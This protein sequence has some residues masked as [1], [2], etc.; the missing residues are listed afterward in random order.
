MTVLSRSEAVNVPYGRYEG[1]IHFAIQPPEDLM[2]AGVTDMWFVP[3]IGLVKWSSVWIGGVHSFEL[4]KLSS[5]TPY[6]SSG[7]F[8]G[9]ILEITQATP[10]R[11]G[12]GMDRARLTL[13][14]DSLILAQEG[15]SRLEVA[16]S[17]LSIGQKV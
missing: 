13:K 7:S 1:S 8:S 14:D 4:S 11:P 17:A 6:T 2:D 9:R 15:T 5:F 12:Q 16:F 10:G 3:N